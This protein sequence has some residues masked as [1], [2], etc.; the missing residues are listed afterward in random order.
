MNTL[1][2]DVTGLHQARELLQELSQDSA[3]LKTIRKTGETVL[4]HYP[5]K[6]E[7]LQ[8][9]KRDEMADNVSS[10]SLNLMST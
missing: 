3:W 5:S 8:I 2:H 7:V 4:R 6:E 10:A 9:G 1:H